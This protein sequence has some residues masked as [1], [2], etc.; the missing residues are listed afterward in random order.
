MEDFVF[1][2]DN[3]IDEEGEDEFLSLKN[4]HLL[5][6][7]D[8]ED[9]NLCVSLML[10]AIL[11]F[12]EKTCFN[13]N[14]A[15]GVIFFNTKNIKAAT[16][17]HDMEG[18]YCLS[19]II[20]PVS[21][22]LIS[23]LNLFC[24]REHFDE[25]ISSS[26]RSTFSDVFWICKHLFR[27]SGKNKQVGQRTIIF[28]TANDCPVV[29]NRSAVVKHFSDL[30][31]DE[32]V[33]INVFG[34]KNSSYELPFNYKSLY[35]SIFHSLLPNNKNKTYRSSQQILDDLFGGRTVASSKA[36]E[37]LF[38]LTDSITLNINF[39]IYA[40]EEK[41]PKYQVFDEDNNPI[42]T[43]VFYNTPS[44]N[45][46][47]EGKREFTYRINIC[48]TEL[49]FTP[50]E[51][52]TE[53]KQPSLSLLSIQ[54]RSFLQYYYSIG[55]SYFAFANNTFS[56]NI[57]H[58]FLTELDLIGKIAICVKTSSSGEERLV[59]CLPSFSKEKTLVGMNLIPLPFADEIRK[60]PPSY[61]SSKPDDEKVKILEDI[62][63]LFTIDCYD[64]KKYPNP[65]M[66]KF[67][68]HL[69]DL[70]VERE[71]E[72][73]T[74]EQDSTLMST[75]DEKFLKGLKLLEIHRER[76]MREESG[77]SIEGEKKR[78]SKR[79]KEEVDLPGEIKRQLRDDFSFFSSQNIHYLRKCAKALNITLS[80]EMKKGDIL[81]RIV[82]Y[83]Q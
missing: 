65:T 44:D 38:M 73:C 30:V 9:S 51:L 47:N 81:D 57:L 45:I 19:P 72:N 79:K 52:K 39:F 6:I 33:D 54:P 64:P 21:V 59:A 83:Y 53:K 48:G 16:G 42:I 10:P 29:G 12:L 67:K 24:K 11:E 22:E 3:F 69:R 14:N 63:D 32:E 36:T 13:A 5:F 8:A 80:R 71:I 23:S 78:S 15:V 55:H 4:E 76:I 50:L 68:K 20:S 70:A 2:N 49:E 31:G 43:K 66:E 60:L 25:E 61:L 1:G 27:L 62:V 46:S 75:E 35:E 41:M 40:K 7:I 74:E 56:Y 82:K 37:L 28:F 18:I 77:D 34:V 17:I 26:N 58:S